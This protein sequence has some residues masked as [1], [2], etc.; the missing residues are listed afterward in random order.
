MRR[1]GSGSESIIRLPWVFIATDTILRKFSVIAKVVP[2]RINPILSKKEHLGPF[3]TRI[4]RIVMDKADG[5]TG[6][7]S[8]KG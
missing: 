3:A 8:L 4:S 5:R 2:Q 1:S 7:T 6:S